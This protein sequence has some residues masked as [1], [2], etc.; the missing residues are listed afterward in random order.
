MLWLFNFYP[1]WQAFLS[2]TIHEDLQ[3]AHKM[4]KD[5]TKL[6]GSSSKYTNIRDFL[7]VIKL[8]HILWNVMFGN[9]CEFKHNFSQALIS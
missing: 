6:F 4:N 8:Y 1:L 7:S 2:G 3:K 5:I 9:H